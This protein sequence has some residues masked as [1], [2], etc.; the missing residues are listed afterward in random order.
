M[1]NRD[2]Y[3]ALAY[4]GR[5]PSLKGLPIINRIGSATQ[6]FNS[7]LEALQAYGLTTAAANDLLAFR[8]TFNWEK[9][10]T[11]LIREQIEIITL[12][13]EAYPAMLRELPDAP[14]CLFVRGSLE[15]L[16]NPTVAIVGTRRA[17]SYAIHATKHFSSGLTKAGATIISGLALGIDTAAHVACLESGGQTIAVLGGGIDEPTLYPKNN[18]N[19]A[20]EIIAKGGAVISEFPPQFAPTKY[21]FPLRNRIVV[22]LSRGVLVTEAPER[23]G[24]LITAFLA[25]E[26]NRDCFAIPADLFR[27]NALG[28]NALLSQGARIVLSPNDIAREYNLISEAPVAAPKLEGA[29]AQIFELIKQTARSIDELHDETGLDISAISSMLSVMELAGYIKNTGGGAF[30]I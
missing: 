14:Y 2:A 21:T 4:A 10:K 27:A 22:G 18:L 3:I 23:S 24:A 13:D 25:L 26:Y 8:S 15:S 5:V 1:S 11:R 12:A 16:K 28:S 6:F 17:T 9:E 30:S 29:E 19:L 7:S 20:K